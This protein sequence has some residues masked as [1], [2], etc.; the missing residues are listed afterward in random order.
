MLLLLIFISLI[1]LLV[2][3]LVVYASFVLGIKM[4]HA[5]V[6]CNLFYELAKLKYHILVLLF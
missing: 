5:S 6:H 3:F 1:S 2:P 4:I